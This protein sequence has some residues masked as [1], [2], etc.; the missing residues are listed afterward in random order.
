MAYTISVT[1]L[2]RLNIKENTFLKCFSLGH[3][4]PMLVFYL[5]KY[6][7]FITTFA[8]NVDFLCAGWST[9]LL[10]SYATAHRVVVL[11]QGE[12]R[13]LFPL[14]HSFPL[15]QHPAASHQQGW[16]PAE[17][18]M[19]VLVHLAQPVCFTPTLWLLMS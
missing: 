5:P 15:S 2:V 19:L 18:K 11:Y 17:P 6:L 16:G 1:S 9:A 4:F 7:H 8:F 14:S 3:S 12:S 13:A 10:T